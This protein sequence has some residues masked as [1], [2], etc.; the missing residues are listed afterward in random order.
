M[1]CIVTRRDHNLTEIMRKPA[2]VMPDADQIV[3]WCRDCG[4][5]VIDIDADDQTHPGAII[6]MT[7][8]LLALRAAAKADR[9]E[10]L[11]ARA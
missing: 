6:P 10:I 8:P 5:I 7:F 2:Y 4:A 3:R 1:S 9:E 11:G